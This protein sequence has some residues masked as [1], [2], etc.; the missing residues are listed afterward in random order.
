[1]AKPKEAP[2]RNCVGTHI[3]QKYGINVEDV[4]IVL[5]KPYGTVSTGL[6]GISYDLLKNKNRAI[7]EMEKVKGI[8]NEK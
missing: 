4:A 6:I 2:L 7:E 1:M 5:N 3:R 8:F